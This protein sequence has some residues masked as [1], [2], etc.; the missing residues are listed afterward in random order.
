MSLRLILEEC[1]VVVSYGPSATT[2]RALLSGK[3]QLI[4]PTDVE[5]WLIGSR[6][7]MSGA[8]LMLD[9]AATADRVAE[10]L[11]RLIGDAGPTAKAAEIASRYS[12]LSARLAPAADNVIQ[13]FLR[14]G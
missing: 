1:N 4:L 9:G 10:Q 7:V 14:T 5:K 11:V 13:S 2:T 12:A 3:P 8:A 6:I